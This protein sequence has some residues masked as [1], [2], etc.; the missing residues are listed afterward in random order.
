MAQPFAH[1]NFTWDVVALATL[2]PKISWQGHEMNVDED[3]ECP[4]ANEVSF[5]GLFRNFLHG[6]AFCPCTMFTCFNQN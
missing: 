4:V 6:A 1:G 5:T 3:F 2:R